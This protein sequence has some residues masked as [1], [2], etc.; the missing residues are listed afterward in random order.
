MI[1][2]VICKIDPGVYSE[3]T[4]SFHPR[5]VP[6]GRRKGQRFGVESVDDEGRGDGPVEINSGIEGWG[7]ESRRGKL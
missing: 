5:D 2:F 4:T 3:S 6:W 7:S 1:V